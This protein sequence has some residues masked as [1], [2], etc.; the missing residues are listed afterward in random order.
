VGLC[1]GRME[2]YPRTNQKGLIGM[3]ATPRP[4]LSGDPASHVELERIFMEMARD[5]RDSQIAYAILRLAEAIQE[6]GLP[7][8]KAK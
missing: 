6:H 8:L 1:Q 7:K 5:H 4:A 2:G 3:N